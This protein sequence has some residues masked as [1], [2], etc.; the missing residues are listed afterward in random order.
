MDNKEGEFSYEVKL[1]NQDEKKITLVAIIEDSETEK[2]ITITLSEEYITFL[3]NKNH[4]VELIKALPT[5]D[6][7]F[8]IRLVTVKTKIEKDKEERALAVAAEEAK[9]QQIASESVALSKG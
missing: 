6:D 4:A 8:S 2:V 3:M 5:K 1:V 9:Q 7:S